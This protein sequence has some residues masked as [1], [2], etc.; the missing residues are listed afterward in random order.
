MKEFHRFP[1]VSQSVLAGS[2]PKSRSADPKAKPPLTVVMAPGMAVARR[3]A[4]KMHLCLLE[5]AV[6]QAADPAYVTRG[7]ERGS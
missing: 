6:S 2:G 3:D 5:S 1:R 4:V 7:A